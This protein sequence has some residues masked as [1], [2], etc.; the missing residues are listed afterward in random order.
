[1]LGERNRKENNGIR[2]LIDLNSLIQWILS[3]TDRSW[4]EMIGSSFRNGVR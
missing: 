1:M 4:V 3:E 2:S